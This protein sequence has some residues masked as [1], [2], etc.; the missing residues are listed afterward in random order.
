[1]IYL[2]SEEKSG[3]NEYGDPI[4]IPGQKR[5][6]FATKKS[7]TRNE[8]YQ[9]AVTDFRPELSFIIWQHEYKGEPNIKFEEKTYNIIRTY[10]TDEKELELVCQGLSNG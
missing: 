10:E 9:A 5:K 4:T 8:F 1:M 7:I 3:K 6:I 2:V